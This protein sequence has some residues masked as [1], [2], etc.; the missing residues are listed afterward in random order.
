MPTPARETEFQP[1]LL[2]VKGAWAWLYQERKVCGDASA[3]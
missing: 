2:K 3:L 1:F